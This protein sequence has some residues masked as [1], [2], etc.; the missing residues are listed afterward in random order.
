MDKRFEKMFEVMLT[1]EKGKTINGYVNDPQDAGGETIMGVCR[2]H[3][4]NLMVW[5]SLDKLKT[6]KEKKMYYLTLDEYN[7]IVSLYYR[8]YYKK[9][10][11]H[12][13][14]D[15]ALA[16]QIF[17]WAVNAGSVRAVKEIQKLLHVVVDGICGL[18]T[19]TVINNSKS[20][21]LREAYRSARIA[22][23]EALGRKGDNGKFLK[24]WTLRAQNCDSSFLP[25]V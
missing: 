25:K 4:P 20:K 12:C 9:N 8:N 24:G 11:L 15:D 13:V 3:Y 2:K 17:D 18:Q 16:M 21:A 10:N 23:Y 5:A 7:E 19:V 22:F 14:E 1:Y 6:K